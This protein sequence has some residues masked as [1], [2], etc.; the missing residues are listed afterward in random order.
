MV[1]EM[2]PKLKMHFRY[3]C[4]TFKKSAKICICVCQ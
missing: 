4:L 3:F 2:T 1:L